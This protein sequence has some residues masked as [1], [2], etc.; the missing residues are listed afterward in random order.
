MD[1]RSGF[2]LI[3]LSIVMVI[4]G[5]IVGGVLV[6]RDMIIAAQLRTIPAQVESTKSAI[7][8]FRNKYGA[9]P[10][11]LNNSSRFFSGTLNGDGNGLI[12]GYYRE[13]PPKGNEQWQVWVHLSKAGLIEGSYTGTSGPGH[14]CRNAV[15]GSNIPA[16]KYGK[17][18]MY[19][20]FWNNL[21][22]GFNKY[23]FSLG[24]GSPTG[25]CEIYYPILTPA[26]MASLDGKV[27][28]GKP[29]TGTVWDLA[30]VAPS[31]W[32]SDES[33]TGL[34]CTNANGS[35]SNTNAK[36]LSNDTESRCTP[37]FFWEP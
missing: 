22:P 9:L 28:D 36:Y 2:T 18:G 14:C 29:F 8:T 12:D 7:M 37:G 26:Q 3:E 33:T 30:A 17:G 25:C 1:H 20:G 24:L 11:D 5:L 13:T 32:G 10:G 34:W 35:Y 15:P 23:V 4:I 31:N 21:S 27:D 16:L 6:G 19:L